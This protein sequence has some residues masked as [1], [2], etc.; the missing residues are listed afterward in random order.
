MQ[1]PKLELHIAQV[2]RLIANSRSKFSNKKKEYIYNNMLLLFNNIKKSDYT[3]FNSQNLAITKVA[4]NIIFYAIEFLD[5]KK[6]S[7]IPKRLI[8]CLNKVLDEWILDGTDKYFIVVSY[9]NTA[10]NFF[11]KGYDQEYLKAL[12]P[13]LKILF[14]VDCPQS[15]IQ[16]SKPKF[17]FN[18]YLSSIPLYHELGHFI[19]KNYQIIFNFSRE[20]DFA[21]HG[22]T[23]VHFS[24]FFADLFAAQYIGKCTT[25][26][27]DETRTQSAPTH[28]SNAKRVEVVNTF[29]E[30]TGSPDCMKIVN[31]LRRVTLLRTKQELKI[32]YENIA[33]EENPFLT[34]T[35]EILS[36]PKKLHS[37]FNAGWQN[38]LDP[39]SDIR[40]KYPKYDECSTVIN[41]LIRNS[42]KLTMQ[43]AESDKLKKIGNYIENFANKLGFINN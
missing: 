20:S 30:G 13:L 37:L 33:D 35:P 6:E 8:F 38:W 22:I 10:D 34:L 36:N 17:L 16:I 32:R 4:L 31:E 12:I 14:N 26:P 24:E 41:E 18:D 29:I 27:L 19:D 43:Q 3:N 40:R 42:I 39:K 23:D 1:Y 2:D 9:N 21:T 15:L 7:D 5:Y 11:I 25:A 28:P